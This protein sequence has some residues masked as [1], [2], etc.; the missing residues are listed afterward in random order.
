MSLLQ[1]LRAPGPKRILALDGG[2]IRGALTLGYLKRVEAILRTRH[3]RPD[4][5]LCDYFDLIGGTSTG[6]ILAAGLAIGMTAE[7][8]EKLYLDFGGQVFSKLQLVGRVGLAGKYDDRPLKAKLEEFF[9]EVRLGGEEVQTG[10]CIVTKR[11]DTNSTWPL[12]N[13]PEGRYYR[14]NNDILLRDAV[15]AST[16]APTYFDPQDLNFQS[17]VG[18]LDGQFVDGGVSMHN[19]PAMLLFLI[20]TLEGFQFHWPAGEHDL[21]LVSIGTGFWGMAGRRANNVVGWGKSVP[22]M[23]MDDAAWYNQLLLQ[24]LSH[25]PTASVIDREI[26]DLRND[27]LGGRPLLTYLRY[28][29]RLDHDGLTELDLPGLAATADRLQAMDDAG[30]RAD[31]KRIGQTAAERHVLP[32]HFPSAFDLR[33]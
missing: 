18:P 32:Q 25:S 20:A 31:L 23:L 1:R 33:L 7:Q 3:E 26:G 10:L 4:L 11:A 6:A 21:L 30:N 28:D 15:R 2:G 27:V 13:H 14:H 5:R 22:T 17:S 24:Y 12:L 9:K 19:N 29:A 16:A 8:L